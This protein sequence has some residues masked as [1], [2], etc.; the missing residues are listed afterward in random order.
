MSK[1]SSVAK[2][3]WIGVLVSLFVLVMNVARVQG[4]AENATISGTATDASGGAL[5]GAK[6]EATNPATNVSRS[7][8]TD[9]EGRYR[10]SSVPVGTYTVQATLSGFKTVVHADVVLSVGGTI[11]VDFS[12]PVGQVSQTVTV[13]AEVSRVETES[14]EISTLVSPQQIRELPLNGRNFT[15]LLTLAPGVTTIPA[16]VNLANFVVGRMY[17][18]MDNYSVSGSRPTGQQFL[19]DGVDIRDFWEH[20]TG[21]GYGGTNLGIEAI[22][23]VQAL[24]NTYNAQF[25]G[26]GVVMNVASRSGTNDLH[27]GVYE[28]FRNNALDSRALQDKN[29]G[30]SEAPP[31]RRNQFGGALGGAIKKDKL[32]FFSN[33]EGLRQGLDTTIFPIDLPEDYVRNGQAPCTLLSAGYAGCPATPSGAPGSGTNPI[34]TVHPFNGSPQAAANLAQLTN[35]MKLYNLC[36]KTCTA[37]LSPD[38]G[39][40]YLAGE[41]SIL[42]VNEDYTLNRVDYTIGP[43]DSVFGRYVFDN[44]TVDDPR[45]PMQIFPEID[46]TRNQFAVITEKHIFSTTMV[47]SVRFGYTRTKEQSAAQFHLSPAQLTAVGLDADPLYLAAQNDYPSANKLPDAQ[48][49]PGFSPTVLFPVLGPDGDRPLNI[50]QSKFSGGDD[51]VWTHGKHT[52]KIGAV[53]QRVDTNNLQLSYESGLSFLGW[54]FGANGGS[55]LQGYFEGHPDFGF[56][57]APGFFDATRYYREIG[58]APYLQD[59]W[60]ITSKL[61]LNLGIRYDYVTNPKVTSPEGYASQ[62]VGSFLPPTGPLAVAPNCSA[63]A[64]APNTTASTT[65]FI[66]CALGIYSHVKHAFASNPNAANWA[67]RVGFAWDVFNDHKTSIRGGV[68]LFHD[69]VEARIESSGFNFTPP[70]SAITMLNFGPAVPSAFGGGDPCFPDP[71]QTVANYCGLNNPTAGEFAAVQYQAPYGS[72]YAL[73]YNLSVQRE[74]ARGT[75]LSVGYVGSVARHMWMQRDE[76]P[77]RCDAFPDCGAAPQIPTARPDASDATYTFI[78]GAANFCPGA[79][80]NNATAPGGV[81]TGC[82]GSGPHFAFFGPH[83]TSNF[84]SRVMEAETSS[85]SYSSVQVSLNHQFGRDISGQVNYSYSHCIDDG[86]FATSLEFWGQLMTDAYNQR[87]DYE[88]CLFDIRH[89]LV[90][91]GVFSLPFKGNRFVE[92]WQFATILSIN[93]GTPIN[94]TNNTAPGQDPS[95]LGSQ[96]ATRPNYTFAAGCS[97][98]HVVGQWVNVPIGPSNFKMY[99][100]FNPNCYEQQAFGY[101]GNVKR[102]SLPG[103]PFINDDFSIIKNTKIT[104]KV[105]TQFR[106]E[107][108]NIANHLNAGQPTENIGGFGPF[109]MGYSFVQAGNPRQIQFSLKLDF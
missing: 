15:Q 46:H 37:P 60:K 44:T 10:I 28:F 53:V 47:N 49:G 11:I 73:Q 51:L 65:P 109:P 78:P 74:V 1:F 97:P 50:I 107:F 82:Y 7:T 42:N 12:M 27:G 63:F 18:A 52:T 79:Q 29:S 25:A 2:C 108:F 90:A 84:G 48:V 54:S 106:A 69:P 67:P 89:N 45:D 91:N 95:Q 100:D 59:D 30:L 83:I 81:G 14:S 16:S 43:N 70:A 96:W 94:I 64:V 22:G 9:A 92:G 68:G 87:Y 88:N 72:P 6:V 57:N 105:N 33:Y 17:G 31:F 39:G 13:E 71:F 21:S 26:N 66:Q 80:Q 104:E 24:T 23:E 32:F 98:N 20:S 4:Q 3:V 36:T 85:S 86:S 101:I 102:D 58:L 34:V 19:L 55:Q 56:E 77:P 40:Y 103:I 75:V 35:I 61:T 99:E 41:T 76:N 38:L 93:S 8:T 62:V 5:A